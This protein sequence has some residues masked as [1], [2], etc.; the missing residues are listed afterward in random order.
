MLSSGIVAKVGAAEVA[1]EVVVVYGWAEE[2]DEEEAVVGSP[3]ACW[4]M[5]FGRSL[6]SGQ[7]SAWHGRCSR[8]SIA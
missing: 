7:H 5:L 1:A 3:V 2:A 6:M 8:I 4:A